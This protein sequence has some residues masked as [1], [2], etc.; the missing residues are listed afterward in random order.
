MLNPKDL[1]LAL[2]LTLA[3]GGFVATG[4]A[5]NDSAQQDAAESESS[6]AIDSAEPTPPPLTLRSPLYGTWKGDVTVGRFETLVLM[7]D[8]RYHV[9]RE[10]VCV[11]A[12]CNPIVEDGIFSLSGQDEHQL[13]LFHDNTNVPQTYE[14]KLHDNMLYIRPFQD[15]AQWSSLKK[16]STGWCAKFTDCD[17]QNLPP[18]IC[19][20]DYVCDDSVCAW[21]CANSGQQSAIAP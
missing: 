10:V 12:P 3:L 6:E 17:V 5:G 8:Y 20:G 7:T 4:C 11:K 19:S 16:A 15:G 9:A 18:G 14:Y 1:L 2:P 21:Q 13:I